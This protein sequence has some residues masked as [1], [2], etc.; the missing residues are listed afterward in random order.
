MLTLHRRA[1]WQYFMDS[2]HFS[3]RT[4][5]IDISHWC[6][7]LLHWQLRL[8]SFVSW[9]VCIDR[10]H[11]PQWQFAFMLTVCNIDGSQYW[12]VN[13]ACHNVDT[14]HWQLTLTKCID[15]SCCDGKQVGRF[16]MQLFRCFFLNR[17]HRWCFGRISVKRTFFL[18]VDIEQIESHVWT[19]SVV[20]HECFNVLFLRCVSKSVLEHPCHTDPHWSTLIHKNPH[21][22]TFLQTCP[23]QG[24]SLRQ[25]WHLS[26]FSSRPRFGLRQN[27]NNFDNRSHSAYKRPRVY[28]N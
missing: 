12:W 18:G 15:G 28:S 7:P 19:S 22:S 17:D 8:V 21:W 26:G 24:L 25:V 2:G 1:Y 4:G 5:D 13:C 10:S 20:F 16:G 9:A 14:S 23:A 6:C 27:R 3:V 11:W